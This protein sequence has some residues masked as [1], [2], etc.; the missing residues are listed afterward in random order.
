MAADYDHGRSAHTPRETGCLSPTSFR[1]V[2]MYAALVP[3][4]LSL[5]DWI[6]S[7]QQ[8]FKC[9]NQRESSFLLSGE[10]S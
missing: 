2:A 5:I 7:L 6:V 1:A 10:T 4:P 3:I 9:Q 8:P